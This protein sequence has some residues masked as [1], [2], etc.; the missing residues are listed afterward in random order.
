[1]NPVDVIRVCLHYRKKFGRF[2]NLIRPRTFNEK[3][4]VH[5]L[6]WRSPLLG[7]FVDKVRAK[8]FVAEHF[9]ADLVTPSYYTGDSLPPRAERNWP[10]PYVI[11]PN[12]GSGKNIF[13]RTEADL[14]WDVIEARLARAMRHPHGV[15]NGEWAY[16]QVKPK[17]LV[18]PFLGENGVT[19]IEFKFNTFG[20]R[21]A[22][23]GV[24]T[25]RY[26]D[27]HM[28]TYDPEWQPYPVTFATAKVLPPIPP[29]ADLPRMLLIAE[30]FGKRLPQCRIDFYEIDGRAR[31]GEIT[32]YSGAGITPVT[33]PEYDRILGDLIPDGPPADTW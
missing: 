11:K 4:T 12:H 29:P 31:F 17:V 33:P 10:L 20:G 9:G 28:Q 6:T 24:T 14:D 21:V 22:Y 15:K 19:P 2:P 5:K 8:E 30:E 27:I 32:I 18:E 3:V 7:V 25:D 13:V 23:V 26:G 16:T 1:M